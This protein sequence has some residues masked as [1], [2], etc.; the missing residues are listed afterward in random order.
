M[1]KTLKYSHSK[2]CCIVKNTKIISTPDVIQAD[3]QIIK[4][5]N[6]ATATP[7]T[8]KPIKAIRA[9]SGSNVIKH[10]KSV[11]AIKQPITVDNTPP[12]ITLDE[13]RRQYFNNAKQQ[14]IQRTSALFA[15]AF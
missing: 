11:S 12:I 13:M 4:P 6:D 10:V 8:I 7:T 1:N 3:D 9:K 15:N 14:R 2:T 5:A